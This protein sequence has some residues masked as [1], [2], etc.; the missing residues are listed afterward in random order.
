MI[1]MTN[2]LYFFCLFLSFCVWI[3][4]SQLTNNVFFFFLWGVVLTAL[5]KNE[6]RGDALG[7]QQ[8]WPLW[9]D[10]MH[11]SG[12]VVRSATHIEWC[13][14][15]QASEY[16]NQLSYRSYWSHKQHSLVSS[17]T[18]NVCSFFFGDF[19]ILIFIFYFYVNN[20]IYIP[21]PF[22]WGSPTFNLTDSFAMMAASFVTLFEVKLSSYIWN[23]Y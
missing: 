1:Y 17:S 18:W 5:S 22:Q 14:W 19:T 10:V 6:E 20:R 23:W 15:P 7:W 21:Y 11:S 8:M 2:D 12:M 3:W 13:L 9:D 4:H 16:S